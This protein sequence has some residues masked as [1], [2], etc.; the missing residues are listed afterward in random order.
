MNK[1]DAIARPRIKIVSSEEIQEMEQRLC[2][3]E[4]WEPDLSQCED[5][6]QLFRDAKVDKRT[7][8]DLFTPE[9]RVTLLDGI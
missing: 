5:P 6:S 9:E 4:D 2:E 7:I 1:H 3:S 8:L